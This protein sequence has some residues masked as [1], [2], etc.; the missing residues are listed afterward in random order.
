MF[1]RFYELGRCPRCGASRVL[2][3]YVTPGESTEPQPTCACYAEEEEVQSDKDMERTVAF[4]SAVIDAQMSIF[5]KLEEPLD[6]AQAIIMLG[7]R[8]GDVNEAL[9][10]GHPRL[11]LHA[12]IK[13]AAVA[14]YAAT[15]TKELVEAVDMLLK[16]GTVEDDKEE[17]SDDDEDE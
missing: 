2:P 15:G 11:I 13:A 6:S 1:G 14:R 4:D 16:N 12:L 9:F 3:G 10:N 7:A 8:I 5:E 17:E